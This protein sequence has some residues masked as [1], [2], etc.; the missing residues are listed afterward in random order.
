MKPVTIIN[1]IQV[2]PGKMDEFLTAQRWFAGKIPS[3][4]LVGG[5]MYRSL[6]GTSAVLVSVFQ[7]KSAQ[8]EVI[9]RSDFKAHLE[10]LQPL[11]ESSSPAL[12]EEAYT[13]GDFR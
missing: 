4:V 12:Y 13:T 1:R 2:K 10:R 5:R 7:S 9:Q 6:D 8:E 3:T 11:V